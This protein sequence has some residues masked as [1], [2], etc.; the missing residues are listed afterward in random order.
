[1]TLA[2]RRGGSVTGTSPRS[3]PWCNRGVVC[4]PDTDLSTTGIH[5]R[6]GHNL[7]TDA[8]GFPRMGHHDGTSGGAENGDEPDCFGPAEWGRT[9]TPGVRVLPPELFVRGGSAGERSVASEP[10]HDT[11]FVVTVR[12]ARRRAVQ[13]DPFLRFVAG[14]GH[15][16][17]GARRG[18]HHLRPRFSGSSTV[19]LPVRPSSRVVPRAGTTAKCRSQAA[20]GNL[21]YAGLRHVH[22]SGF[23]HLDRPERALRARSTRAWAAAVEAWAR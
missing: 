14:E 6:V 15:P 21:L 10:D 3:S 9:G 8:C 16:G 2:D 12:C 7:V 22:H 13:P 17:A 19:S 23:G 5:A 1:M 18:R 4:L 20:L 11:P